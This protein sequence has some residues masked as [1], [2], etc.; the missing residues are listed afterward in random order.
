MCTN[1]NNTANMSSHIITKS[2]D[3]KWEQKGIIK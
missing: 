3:K 1:G 2:I